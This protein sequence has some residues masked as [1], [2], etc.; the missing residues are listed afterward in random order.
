MQELILIL[1]G[2]FGMSILVFRIQRRNN[3]RTHQNQFVNTEP[4][5]DAPFDEPYQQILSNELLEDA[6]AHYEEFKRK[7]EVI[8][9][10]IP[11][12]YFGDLPKYSNASLKVITVGLNPSNK[13]FQTNTGVQSLFR[14]KSYSGSRIS[15]E[16]SLSKY[17]YE[18][19]YLK[20]FKDSYEPLL[21]GMN[22]SYFNNEYNSRAIH[23]DLV[24]PL[25]TDPTWSELTDEIKN[26]L[27][28]VGISLWA[29]TVS[30]LDPHV[31]IVSIG[32]KHLESLNLNLKGTYTIKTGKS[33]QAST[34]VE[35]YKIEILGKTYPLFYIKGGRLPLGFRTRETKERIGRLITDVLTTR[36]L[37]PTN[38]PPV[39]YTDYK[40][41]TDAGTSQRIQL[42]TNFK[43]NKAW[44]G[45]N[46]IIKVINQE[47]EYDHD[48]L[49]NA[50]KSRFTEGGRA[51]NSWSKYG[52]Y[53]KTS[54]W[55][56]WAADH[57]KIIK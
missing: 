22:S 52:Y 45:Q 6:L 13:E 2:V 55:P 42:S 44:L 54:G 18:E 1:A 49:F 23:T 46:L 40:M 5:V 43:L 35:H 27:K 31:I 33:K 3:V 9:P 56:N 17:F 34:D 4:I 25:A 30:E 39:D 38:E 50:V 24:S 19:P 12:L 53:V 41:P 28:E 20:W 37:D 16:E 11:V 21:N 51:Y 36:Q 57:I 32:K 8:N 47:F 15:F 48:A 7:D 14:F 29:R 10:S 26:E